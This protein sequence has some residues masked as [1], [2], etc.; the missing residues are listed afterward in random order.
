MLSV[1]Y[2]DKDSFCGQWLRALVAARHLPVGYVDERSWGTRR[3][4]GCLGDR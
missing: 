2:N 1:Y 3:S 4:T